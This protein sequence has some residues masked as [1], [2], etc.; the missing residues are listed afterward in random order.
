M[1]TRNDFLEVPLDIA[2]L[3]H[4]TLGPLADVLEAESHPWAP[5]L[6][7]VLHEYVKLRNSALGPA[8]GPDISHITYL[9]AERVCDLTRN[10]IRDEEDFRRWAS[11]MDAAG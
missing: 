5:T 4:A 11:E 3:L 10:A 9:A 1:M 6:H 7:M 2:E 8:L